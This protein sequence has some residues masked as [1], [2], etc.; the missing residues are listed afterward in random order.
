MGMQQLINCSARSQSFCSHS[1][2]K[3]AQTDFWWMPILLSNCLG[4]IC[5]T[6]RVLRARETWG[7]FYTLL[8]F[9]ISL[10]LELALIN[11]F[12]SRPCYGKIICHPS[13]I[14]GQNPTMLP[15]KWIS[16]TE[17]LHSNTYF[18]GFCKKKFDL[19]CEFSLLEFC[20]SDQRP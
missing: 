10:M 4:L 15:F 1:A 6:K 3:L 18:I 19:F 5:K 13:W 8:Y 17:F 9:S 20:L 14:S 11:L 12:A 2:W 7:L 16:L